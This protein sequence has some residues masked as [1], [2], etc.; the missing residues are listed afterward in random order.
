MNVL[1]INED[2]NE[3]SVVVFS[4]P[5]FAC[6]ASFKLNGLIDELKENGQPMHNCMIFNFN[7][8]RKHFIFLGNDPFPIDIDINFCFESKNKVFYSTS[9]LLKKPS[10]VVLK[11]RKPHVSNILYDTLL[12]Q[13]LKDSLFDYNFKENAGRRAKE[14]KIGTIIEKV[15]LWRKLFSG[16]HLPGN[17]VDMDLDT[18]AK[19]VGISKKTLDDYLM[20]IRFFCSFCKDFHF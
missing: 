10:K 19:Q 5:R 17:R 6:E 1:I 15:A 3:K 4:N 20:Q 11:Y 16:I 2:T 8:E 12:D 13:S 18:A 14:K 9:L 7:P